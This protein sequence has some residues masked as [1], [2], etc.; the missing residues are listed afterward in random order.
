MF[1]LVS[2]SV[3][4]HQSH[5]EP[6]LNPWSCCGLN[7]KDGPSFFTIN[8]DL[9]LLFL[10]T[11]SL[12]LYSWSHTLVLTKI[13]HHY[14]S[15][16]SLFTVSHRFPGLYSWPHTSVSLWSHQRLRGCLHHWTSVTTEEHNQWSPL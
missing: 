9:D 8:C 3:V 13:E 6:F 4:C 1:V 11:V 7:Y 15:L 5:F 16:F 14:F 12:A 2:K 10:L